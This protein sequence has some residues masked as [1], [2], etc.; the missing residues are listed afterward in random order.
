MKTVNSNTAEQINT[1]L[2]QHQIVATDWDYN[3]LAQDLHNWAERFILEFKL[4]CNTPALTIERLRIGTY[5]HFHI[6]RNA[7]GLR[8]EIAIN[9]RHICMQ[10]YWEVLGTLLHELLHAEQE[11]LGNA[12]GSNY[13]NKAFRERAA[14]LGLIVDAAGHQQYE[15]A[16]SLFVD[17]L[18][19]Y[20]FKA[21]MLPRP[22]NPV[23]Q[24]G[25]S[26]LKAWICSCQ[27][28]IHVRVA[29]S[30]FRARCLNCGQLFR[31]K[32]TG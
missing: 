1:V 27:P 15:P 11:N 23:T 2:K 14:L 3:S 16:P 8:D 9:N 12:S 22:E 17:L 25:K 28:P 21:P 5:G 31:R 24:P 4:K 30:C 29:I 7:F 6:G 32:N 20:G 13:H 10:D 18:Q 19:K 26:K